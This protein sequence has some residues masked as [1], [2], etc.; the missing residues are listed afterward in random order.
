MLQIVPQPFLNETTKQIVTTQWDVMRLR[1]FPADMVIRWPN[2]IRILP[3]FFSLATSQ[4][5]IKLMTGFL[6]N[7]LGIST[8]SEFVF[9]RASE[10][11]E[12]YSPAAEKSELVRR[13]PGLN[14]HT[15]LIA[16]TPLRARL[17][18]AYDR[19][20]EL[21]EGMCL[22]YKQAGPI[23]LLPANFDRKFMEFT[24]FDA[25]MRDSLDLEKEY[26]KA[27]NVSRILLSGDDA[28]SLC[29]YSAVWPGKTE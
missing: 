29:N 16:V 10:Q 4:H 11:S 25:S 24:F 22:I 18:F 1:P 7:N 27:F 21:A 8:L 6:G 12:I 5:C 14:W 3:D 2:M 26:F 15:L 23:S 19:E 9:V 28:G 13:A 17:D 20:V